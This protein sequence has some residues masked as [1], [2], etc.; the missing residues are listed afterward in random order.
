MENLFDESV[1]DDLRI[2]ISANGEAYLRW[3]MMGEQERRRIAESAR[4]MDRE[5]TKKLTDELVSWER[6]HAPYQN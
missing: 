5:H 6:G 1:P 4:G 3:S 2:A